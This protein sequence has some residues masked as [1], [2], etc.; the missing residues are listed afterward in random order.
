MDKSWFIVTGLRGFDEENDYGTSYPRIHKN[1]TETY[2][3]LS[4]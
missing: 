1:R 3:G 4:R 2:K